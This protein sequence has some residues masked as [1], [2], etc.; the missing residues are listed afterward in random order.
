[1]TTKTELS[2]LKWRQPRCFLHRPTV[3]YSY[4]AA[5]CSRAECAQT[6]A[7]E[8]W[9]SRM[10]EYLATTTTGA[11]DPCLDVIPIKCVA[12]P[13]NAA[14]NAVDGGGEAA[15]LATGG[16]FQLPSNLPELKETAVKHK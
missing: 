15:K 5:V 14:G 11:E 6:P 2:L 10:S 16:Q 3:S 9:L 4:R 8:N 12:F 1:M 13:A 7:S